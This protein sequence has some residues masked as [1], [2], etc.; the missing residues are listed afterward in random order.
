MWS[1][2]I[3]EINCSLGSEKVVFLFRTNRN[4][5]SPWSLIDRDIIISSVHSLKASMVTWQA[6]ILEKKLKLW[7]PM[8]GL[9]LFFLDFEFLR[10]QQHS[11]CVTFLAILATC[12]AAVVDWGN[13]NIS[14]NQR[15]GRP[16]ISVSSEKKHHFFRTGSNLPMLCDL[17]N[18]DFFSG[19]STL[20]SPFGL[21]LDIAPQY[22][23]T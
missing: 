7:Q 22:W 5:R 21:L 17:P 12:N 18:V 4:P 15:P 8:R 3:C 13:Y 9:A 20:D 19:L 6:V 23:Y 11:P 14:V 1:D 2:L 16:W 10:K